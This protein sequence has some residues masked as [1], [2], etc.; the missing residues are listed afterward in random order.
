MR[1]S[2]A[3]LTP[4]INT[5]GG[6]KSNVLHPARMVGERYSA[7]FFLWTVWQ[8]RHAPPMA[9]TAVFHAARSLASA[10]FMAAVADWS[11]WLAVLTQTSW[12]LG[13]PLARSNWD[14]HQLRQLLT[15]VLVAASSGTSTG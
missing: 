2:K 11:S 3:Q 13:R 12:S 15:Q 10:A 9:V 4:K 6:A 5:W 8:P 7:F 1:E 14:A